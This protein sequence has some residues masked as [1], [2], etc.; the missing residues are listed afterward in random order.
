M[1]FQYNKNAYWKKIEHTY[2]KYYDY[3]KNVLI[4]TRN[5]DRTDVNRSWAIPFLGIVRS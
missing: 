1:K 4:A 2:N 5:I 3:N